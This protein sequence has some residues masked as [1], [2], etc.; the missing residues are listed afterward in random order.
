[1]VLASSVPSSRNVATS[2]WYEPIEKSCLACS[3]TVMLR[4]FTGWRKT[5][6]PVWAKGRVAHRPQ[7]CQR[8]P[9]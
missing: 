6:C 5:Q 4:L 7:V 1:M 9:P 3:A 2:L 8:D